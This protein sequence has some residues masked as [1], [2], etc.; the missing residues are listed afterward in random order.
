MVG[1]DPDTRMG[2]FV[3]SPLLV[4]EAELGTSGDALQLQ[5]LGAGADLNPFALDLVGIRKE[6][7]DELVTAAAASVEVE[8]S[9]TSTA[10]SHAILHALREEGVDGLD[11]LDPEA[12]ER[13]PDAEGIHNAGVVMT[14]S[15][16]ARTM[17]NLL[18]DL[19]EIANY[20]ELV[21]KGPASVLLGRTPAPN[22]PLPEPHP[23]I[24]LSSQRQDQAVNSAMVNAFTLVTGPPG[25]GKSQVLV[26]VVAATVAR[27]ETVLLA[28]RN[29]RAVDV[30]VDRLRS[31]LTGSIVVRT[32][33]AGRRNEVADHIANAL[34]SSPPGSDPAD[35]RQAWTAVRKSL[36][37]L[38]G[39]LHERQRLRAE[40]DNHEAKV[41]EI[42][43]ACRPAQ[44]P[45]RT[46]PSSRPH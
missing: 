26:N 16:S 18:D 4:S 11:D 27:G 44:A 2:G 9:M 29:N 12:L 41:K 15:A 7:R 42:S 30:V 35:A 19:E 25:T 23:T 34:S 33:S 5:S 17:H 46:L 3:S 31:A 14:T 38:Y 39:S 28:S 37:Q 40:L 20:P 45:S 22:V 36:N 24:A 13:A 10:R 21:A 6:A 1:K 8:E 32:G 43:T